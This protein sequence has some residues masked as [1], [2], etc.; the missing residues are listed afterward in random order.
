MK[1]TDAPSKSIPTAASERAMTPRE[2]SNANLRPWKK[3][4][5]GN[6]SGHPKRKLG[7]WIKIN[8]V[9]SLMAALMEVMSEE[10]YGSPT[11]SR[12]R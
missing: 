9:D 8:S 6:P 7:V 1:P 5:S 3:G 2:R 12:L 4:V 11:R 10:D